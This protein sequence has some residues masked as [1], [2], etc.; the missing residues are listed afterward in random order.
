M[1]EAIN[2]LLDKLEDHVRTHDKAEVWS[3][4]PKGNGTI[5]I[6]NIPLDE[7]DYVSKQVQA[8]TRKKAEAQTDPEKDPKVQTHKGPGNS[9]TNTR[10]SSTKYPK[11]R[12]DLPPKNYMNDKIMHWLRTPKK[13]NPNRDNT[14]A[15][16]RRW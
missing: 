11:Y 4:S 15:R 2:Y 8:I 7:I 16:G 12:V 3:N 13:P 9:R 14:P 1:Q 10:W 6:R 5:I